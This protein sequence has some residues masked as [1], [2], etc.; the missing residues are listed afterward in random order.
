MNL[1]NETKLIVYNRIGKKLGY[2]KKKGREG[3]DV[4]SLPQT[5]SHKR[6]CILLLCDRIVLE[7]Q[8]II[9]IY[10]EKSVPTIVYI[11]IVKYSFIH[12]LSPSNKLK[13]IQFEFE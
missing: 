6:T 7:P 4:P 2:T 3:G 12:V 9:Y 8:C 5:H 1:K 13:H 11:Y 10:I